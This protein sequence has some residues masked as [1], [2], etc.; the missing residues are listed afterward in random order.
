MG[1]QPALSNQSTQLVVKMIPHHPAQDQLFLGT[2]TAD[3]RLTNLWV[4]QF[5]A[6]AVASG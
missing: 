6:S 5:G 4:G 1:L 2:V 3:C